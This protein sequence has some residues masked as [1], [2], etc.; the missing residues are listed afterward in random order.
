MIHFRS[1]AVLKEMKSL[2]FIFAVTSNDYTHHV[3]DE[4]E[5]FLSRK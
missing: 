4:N 5:N 1:S 3:F 2:H